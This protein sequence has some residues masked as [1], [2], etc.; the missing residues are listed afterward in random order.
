MT[1]RELADFMADYLSGEVA[2]E[3]RRQFDHHLSLC[4]NCVKY[5]ASYQTAVE[6]GRRAFEDDDA[7]VPPEVPEE[8][9]RAIVAARKLT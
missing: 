4:P 6:L 1:C 3:T 5:L 9:V 2:I 7:E 8:L